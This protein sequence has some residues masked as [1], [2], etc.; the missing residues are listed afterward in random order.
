MSLEMQCLD[1]SFRAGRMGKKNIFTLLPEKIHLH[2]YEQEH[3]VSP[4]APHK[5]TS[6]SKNFKTNQLKPMI[7]QSL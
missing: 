7:E 6:T 3:S 2:L 1:S 5:L 4:S